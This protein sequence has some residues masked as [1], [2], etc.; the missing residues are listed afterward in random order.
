[1]ISGA[2]GGLMRYAVDNGAKGIMVQAV[3]MGNINVSKCEAE[4]HGC[5]RACRWSFSPGYTMA[6]R[7]R[8]M[9]AI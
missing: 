2:D 8:Y 1:M 9:A 5:P 7:T 6:A 3:G 4:K